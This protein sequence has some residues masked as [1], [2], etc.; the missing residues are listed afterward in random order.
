MFNLE[1]YHLTSLLIS[2]ILTFIIFLTYYGISKKGQF[3]Y[4]L[5]ISPFLLCLFS[6]FIPFQ[7]VLISVNCL[8]LI[9]VINGLRKIKLKEVRHTLNR[10]Y[11]Y[12]KQTNKIEKI[13]LWFCFIHLLS[14]GIGATVFGGEGA[15]VD[16]MTYHLGAPKEWALFLNGPK[17]NLINP[18]SLTASYYEYLLY[19]FFLILRP[20]YAYLAPLEGTYYEFLSYTLLLTGQLFSVAFSMI[21]LPHLLFKILKNKK[22]LF[23][24]VL[25]L[26]LG[27]KG[28]NWVWKTA[29]ND[30][31]ALFCCLVSYSY[32]VK[33]YKTNLNTSKVLIFSFFIVGIGLGSK[34][35]NLYPMILILSFLFLTNVRALIRKYSKVKLAKLVCWSALAGLVSLLPFLLRN[36]IETS[37]PLYPTSSLFFRNI[38]LTDSTEAFHWLY[39]HPVD[40]GLVPLKIKKLF[41]YSPGF[42]LVFCVSLY[43]KKWKECIFF[44]L[45]ALVISK[46]TGERFVWRQI[47]MILFFILIWSESL[48][49]HYLEN[50]EK[51]HKYFPHVVVILL[52]I[53][54]QFKPERLFKYPVRNYLEVTGEVMPRNHSAWKA[55]LNE[56]I[57]HRKNLNFYSSNTSYF[58]RFKHLNTTDSRPEFIKKVIKN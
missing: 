40:W 11:Q 42:I 56:N 6:I 21:F 53:V 16:A 14:G 13:V 19:P 46:V 52:I 43:L 44:F 32:F 31:Y 49:D 41:L 12:Y 57:K 5:I 9:G 35:T 34:M 10:F 45:M 55:Q 47:S 58:S 48:Y 54:S 26:I 51:L 29:K 2:T 3:Y 4:S 7:I 39:S 18:E 23:Y 20:L 8:F 17:L 50:K 15:I 22:E 37:N 24:I 28:I 27:M 36:Y 1:S 25:I 30:F 33:N 38:Y